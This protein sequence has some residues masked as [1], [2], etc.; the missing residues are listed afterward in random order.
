MTMTTIGETSV[1]V[2]WSA[3]VD[4]PDATQVINPATEEV[5]ATYRNASAED[6]DAAVERAVVGARVWR[7]MTPAER[8]DILLKIADAIE[9]EATE[10]AEMECENIGKP[11]AYAVDEMPWA[12]DVFRFFAGAARS[13]HAPAAGEYANGST[14]WLRREPIG[15]VGLIVPWNYPLLMAA[16]KI[17]PAVAAGN[18]V[19]LKPSEL[20]PQTAIKLVDLCNRF[21]PDGV[22]NL[23]LGD[24]TAGQ[25]IVEHPKVRMVAMTGST[26]TG[27]R[28]AEVAA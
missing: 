3:S 2:F 7:R 22:L 21:L 4:A 28:I 16:W 15:V 24:G 6:V 26:A 12:W 13:S 1:G 11:L 19:V 5:I 14:S 8:G 25:A 9:A 10:F 18:A 20:T 23:V 17:A 27:K